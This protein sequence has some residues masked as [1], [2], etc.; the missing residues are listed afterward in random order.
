VPKIYVQR[1]K[2]RECLDY[3]SIFDY[4]FFAPKEATK[5]VFL[6]YWDKGAQQS[7]LCH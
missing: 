4:N 2:I 1:K 6:H 5:N 7:A 3:F